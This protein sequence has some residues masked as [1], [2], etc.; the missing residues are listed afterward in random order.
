M[1]DAGKPILF[2]EASQR[3]EW[4]KAKT[5]LIGL[6]NILQKYNNFESPKRR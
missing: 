6:T 4:L 5:R 3:C 2:A 1:N